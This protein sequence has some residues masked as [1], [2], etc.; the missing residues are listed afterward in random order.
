[1]KLRVSI[2]FQLA[3]VAGVALIAT[4]AFS[5]TTK[6]IYTFGSE[7]NG[8]TPGLYGGVIFDAAG[9]LYGTAQ[10]S[11]A[12]YQGSVYELELN[13]DGTY[14]EI[15]L[16]SF[17]SIA[18]DGATPY[19]SLAIDS[20]GNLYGTTY[21]GGTYGNGTVFELT[22][23][24]SGAWTETLLHQFDA[25]KKDGYNPYAGLVLD[26]KGNLYGTASDGGSE[27]SGTV[28][29]L[30]PKGAGEWKYATLH[31]FN[32]TA[33]G[34]PL[35]AL[36]FDAAGNLY[37][38]TEYGG[39]YEHGVVFELSLNSK[40]TWKETVLHTF[41]PNG[42]DGYSPSSGVAIDS[43]G[44]LYGATPS[45]GDSDNGTVYELSPTTGGK[46]SETIIHSFLATGDGIVPYGSPIVDASGNV[47]GTTWQSLVNNVGGA[48]IVYELSP[49]ATGWQETILNNFIASETYGNPYSGLIFDSKGNLYGTAYGGSTIYEVTP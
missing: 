49:S 3:I 8:L 32:Y 31:N 29:E 36:I 22:P 18:N 35:G 2:N 33:G 20:S 46:W 41:N 34:S 43:K 40:G 10:S 48:G 25:T 39:K 28:F 7:P 19:C 9:N 5:Q 23:S 24:S 12:Y 47:Y 14:T 6:A 27:G 16:Y 15:T 4:Q 30:T 38:T 21:Y 17:G 37:G 11:G 44:N 42:S 13:S 45:G 1:M 26:S